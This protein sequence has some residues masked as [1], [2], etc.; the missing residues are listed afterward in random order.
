MMLSMLLGIV[1]L[2]VP[3]MGLAAKHGLGLGMMLIMSIVH[4]VAPIAKHGLVLGMGVGLAVR[5][6]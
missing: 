1:Q 2:V 3:Y 4:V 6:F 5:N